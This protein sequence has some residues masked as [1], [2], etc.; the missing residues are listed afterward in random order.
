MKSTLLIWSTL[1][2][3]VDLVASIA[4]NDHGLLLCRYLKNGQPGN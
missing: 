4:H 2:F 1:I 3:G